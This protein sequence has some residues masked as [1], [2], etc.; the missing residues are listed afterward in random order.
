MNP[1]HDQMPAE[2]L[3][4]L[5]M[6]Q[7]SRAHSSI[8]AQLCSRAHIFKSSQGS[9]VTHPSGARL[10][11]NSGHIANEAHSRCAG[12]IFNA[13]TVSTGTIVQAPRTTYGQPKHHAATSAG[14]AGLIFKS[15]PDSTRSPGCPRR[16]V[17]LREPV[18]HRA[19]LRLRSRSLYRASQRY[20]VFHG[21][22]AC[23]HFHARP[24]AERLPTMPRR[25]HLPLTP[26]QHDQEGT[27]TSTQ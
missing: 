9:F 27:W 26:N 2:A 12:H 13:A 8:A 14:S 4:H 6:A 18:H 15:R 11:L 16:G 23:A 24:E 10:F 22:H 19:P 7:S 5:V 25:A 21:A 17:L 1:R 3:V 20:L